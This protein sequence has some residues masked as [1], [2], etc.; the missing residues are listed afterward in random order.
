MSAPSAHPK[1][2]LDSALARAIKPGRYSPA[3]LGAVGFVLEREVEFVGGY[4]GDWS[5]VRVERDPADPGGATKYGID[6]ENHGLA[7]AAVAALTLEQAVDAYHRIEWAGIRGDLLPAALALPM[8]DT[9]VNPGV[10]LAVRYLQAAVGATA[11]GWIGP[12]TL[13]ALAKLTPA[14]CRQAAAAVQDARAAYYRARPATLRG[15]PFRTRFLPGW[16]D[17]VALTRQAVADT[18]A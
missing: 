2:S 17:R 8:L 18:T 3:F 16:L 11:D 4:Q 10:R 12:A 13:A 14:G 6:A 1:L 15:R 5:H 7:D 9:A